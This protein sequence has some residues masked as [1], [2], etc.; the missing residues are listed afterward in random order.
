MKHLRMMTGK[1]KSSK[2]ESIAETLI[3][4]LISLA[5]LTMLAYMIT[6]GG[7]LVMGSKEVLKEYYEANNEVA[8]QNEGSGERL[9]ITLAPD[10][11]GQEAM[12]AQ[13]FDAFSYKNE[14]LRKTPVIAYHVD[15]TQT[16]AG[17]GAGSP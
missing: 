6:S 16:P 13:T 5:G 4:L 2:G 17:N 1:V 11:G 15:K 10:G 12:A 3:A 14:T 9:T 8:S 7:K